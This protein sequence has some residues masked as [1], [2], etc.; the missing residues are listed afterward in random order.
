[1]GSV[2]G[3]FV[4]VKVPAGTQA[5]R[6]SLSFRPPGTTLG[7]VLAALGLVLLATLIVLEF[8][9]WARRRPA[10]SQTTRAEPQA[11]DVGEASVRLE[12]R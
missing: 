9:F 11:R 3:V 7:L 5:G 8:V 10:G 2:R 6:L 12:G 4:S 1:V